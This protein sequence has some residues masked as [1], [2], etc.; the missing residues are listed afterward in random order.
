[1][2]F[3]G[4]ALSCEFFYRINGITEKKVESKKNRKIIEMNAKSNLDN[5]FFFYT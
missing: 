1:M 2:D 3:T 4:R 5:G